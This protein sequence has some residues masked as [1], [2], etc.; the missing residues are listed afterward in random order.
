LLQILIFVSGLT[1]HGVV[2]IGT[3]NEIDDH[4]CF[5]GE[6]DPRGRK[7]SFL[8]KILSQP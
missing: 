8:S 4:G 7:W 3:A 5:E 1:A 6:F 2:T